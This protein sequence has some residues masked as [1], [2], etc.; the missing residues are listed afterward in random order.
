METDTKL[1]SFASETVAL[2][3]AARA[4]WDVSIQYGK[5]ITLLVGETAKEHDGAWPQDIGKVCTGV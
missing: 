4:E 2:C 5:V 3:M 1:G